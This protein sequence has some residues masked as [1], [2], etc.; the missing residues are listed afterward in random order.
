[1]TTPQQL[2]DILRDPAVWA[3]ATFGPADLGDDRRSRRAAATA[4]RLAG[5][6][7]AS[8]PT[9]L[10]DPAA[11]KATYRLLHEADV[12][13][14]ALLAPHRAA[15]LTAAATGAEP[16]LL[17]QDTTEV[18]YTAHRAATGLG[19]I[20][21]GGG[22][23]YLLQ[24]VLAVTPT[25]RRVLGLAH[26]D[27]FLRVPAPAPARRSADR[28][29]RARESDAWRRAV[30]AVGPPPPG[31]RWVHVLD[32]GADD[33]AVLDA[34]RT[35]RADVLVRACQDRCATAPDG[36]ATHVLTAARALP[37]Q[38]DRPLDL[39]AQP[40]RAARTAALAVAWTALTVHPPADVR[41]GASLPAW[42]V[43]VWE[44]DP[45][46][47]AEALEWILLTTVPVASTADAWERADWYACRWVVEE[48]H[49]VLK[50]GCRL[51]ASQLRDRE[52]LWRLL[53]LRAPVAVRLLQL[54]D[55]ARTAPA[56]PAA[57]VV[58]AET[59]AVV[60]AQTRAPAAGMTLA[61]FWALVARMGGHQ[62]RR[63]DGPPGWQTLW[64]GWTHLQ[65][66]LD[67]V[68]LARSLPDPRCG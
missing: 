44:P 13:P 60:A 25:P 45:P 16:V 9:A 17:V 15:T 5:A 66:L 32:S 38:A 28:R 40:G 20:G 36:A 68:H 6:P 11:L 55:L 65:T 57:A 12:A 27:P 22:R 67:G 4:A 64:R 43:R 46:P 39:P 62:G 56:T 29:D 42:A 8:L 23:G 14:D 7:E 54:R 37:A 52:A 24:S 2:P 34:C 51:E 21:N 19:P 18:D 58:G 59:V 3:T 30:A 41:A 31:V 33:F 35:Q 10:A 61:V 47:G 48:Y 26:L 53:A 1:M 49:R 50:T 63:G